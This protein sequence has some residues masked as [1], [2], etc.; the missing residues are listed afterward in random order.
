[1]Y[2]S[3]DTR[4]AR[5]VKKLAVLFVNILFVPLAAVV[6]DNGKHQA[7]Y[8]TCYADNDQGLTCGSA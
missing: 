8:G 4:N 3:F 5:F 1:M 2:V 6:A 7:V